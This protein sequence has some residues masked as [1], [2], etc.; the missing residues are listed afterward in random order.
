MKLS[1]K[2]TCSLLGAIALITGGV[3][4][5]TTQPVGPVVIQQQELGKLRVSSA[6]LE[7][8]GNAEGCRQ[9][10]YRC[11]AGLATNGIGNTH[12]VSSTAVSL[13]QV[14]K[15]WV[16]NV[17]SAEQCVSNA[18]HMSGKAMTQGQFDAFTSFVFNTGCTKFRRNANGTLTQIYK[19]I[20]QGNYPKACEQLKRW[21]FSG[22]KK[23]NGLITRRGLEYARCTQVD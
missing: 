1:K 7:L 4:I 17:Q 21:V 8:I 23:Y 13:E 20:M 3:A 19:H 6:A 12:D 10:P 15:D 11:P 18:E 2:I 5:E 14:A 22:G 16:K 9:D